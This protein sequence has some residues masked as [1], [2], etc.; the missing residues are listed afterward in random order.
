MFKPIPGNRDYRIDRRGNICDLN[1]EK[2][3]FTICEG[4]S[5]KIDIF[6]QERWVELEWLALLSW[7][8]FGDMVDL[9]KHLDKIEFRVASKSYMRMTCGKVPYFSKPIYFK[10][11]F[12]HIPTNPRHAIDK[13][14]RVLDT[15]TNGVVFRTYDD[16]SGYPTKYIRTPDKNMNRHQRIHRLLALAWLKNEDFVVR[17]IINHKDGDPSNYD[18]SNIEWCSPQ[19]NAQHALITGLN[20]TCLGVKTRDAYT[21]EVKVYNSFA[22][23]SRN[24][25]LSPGLSTNALK[26][27][28][29]GFLWKKRFE[30][31]RADDSSPWFYENTEPRKDRPTKAIYT[32][33]VRDLKTDQ[34][35]TYH[36][37]DDFVAEFSLDRYK[38]CS[39]NKAIVEFEEKYGDVYGVEAERNA[40]EGPYLLQNLTTGKKVIAPSLVV[41]SDVTGVGRSLLQYDLSRGN[42]CIYPDE[43]I[44]KEGIEPFVGIDEYA[45]KKTRGKKV[46]SLDEGTG[47]EVTHSSVKAASRYTGLNERTIANNLGKGSTVK[48][49]NFRALD[50]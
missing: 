37:L 11:G 20:S 17:P 24:T 35:T 4:N 2:V 43:W 49:Y 44:V 22:D 8:E 38:A 16:N 28:M 30:I 26:G 3:D 29:P 46:V 27:K 12:R 19:E 47:R 34:K 31:K 1:G 41:A 15:R 32:I 6:G 33:T 21:G 36:N 7:Y 10:D 39:V 5:I 25:G 14:G 40:L 23:L 9:A 18:L 48:G 42:K 45:V 50:Q 13:N